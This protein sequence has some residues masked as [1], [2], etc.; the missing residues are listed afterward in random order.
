MEFFVFV[1]N[2]YVIVGGIA[3]VILIILKLVNRN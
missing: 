3:L 1:R 2:A